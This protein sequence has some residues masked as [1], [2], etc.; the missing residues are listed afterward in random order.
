MTPGQSATITRRFEPET[1]AAFSRLVGIDIGTTVPEPLIGALVS[2]LLGVELPGA[3]TNYL[4]Q[5]LTFLKPVPADM[6][7]TATVEITK[8]RP[9]KHLVDLT[10]TCVDDSGALVCRGRALVMVQDADG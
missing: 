2:Y 8:L 1:L 4:K 7:L 3:G 6:A 9:E 5:D 10:T